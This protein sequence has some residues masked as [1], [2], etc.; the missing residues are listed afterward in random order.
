[1]KKI[2]LA[3]TLLIALTSLG[4]ATTANAAEVKPIEAVEGTRDFGLSLEE[5]GASS[6]NFAG[7]T[8]D[9]A[10]LNGTFSFTATLLNKEFTKNVKEDDAIKYTFS[11]EAN[12]KTVIPTVSLTNTSLS[13]EQGSYNYM[14][15]EVSYTLN[16]KDYDS[17]KSYQITVTATDATNVKP[18]EGTGEQE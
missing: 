8:K 18:G 9:S 10:E 2:I 3:T 13:A 11:A 5:Q 1:M 17:T 12:D 14:T 7:I 6:V 16:A 4:L 15:S